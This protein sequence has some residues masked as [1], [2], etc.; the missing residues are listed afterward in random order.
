[1]SLFD[2]KKS[3]IFLNSE[4][5]NVHNDSTLL[6]EARSVVSSTKSKAKS[7]EARGRSLI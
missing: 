3:Q 5:T 4:L 2:R 6:A 7:L 1:M